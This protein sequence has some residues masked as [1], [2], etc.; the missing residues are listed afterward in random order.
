[1]SSDDHLQRFDPATHAGPMPSPC[2]N[3]CQMDPRTGYC[4]GCWR[5]IDEIVAWGS[6]R[7]DFKRAVWV[8]LKR[9]ADAAFGD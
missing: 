3:I 2:I 5:T 1:M 6:A 8:E 7:E 4:V 9:R